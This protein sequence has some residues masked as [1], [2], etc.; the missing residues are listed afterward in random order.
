MHMTDVV[1][2]GGL[3]EAILELAGILKWRVAHFRPAKTEKGWRTPVAADGKGFPDLVLVRGDRLI[4]A[5]LKGPRGRVSPEQQG[6]LDALQKVEDGLRPKAVG[7]GAEEGTVS[8]FQAMLDHVY[9]CPIRVYVWTP[10]KWASGEIER[11]LR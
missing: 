10:A 6:W 8:A 9:P 3:Q 4:F 7:R 5:E 2:E 1:D 11:I